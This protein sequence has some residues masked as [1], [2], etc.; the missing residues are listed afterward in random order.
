MYHDIVT[1]FLSGQCVNALNTMRR[2][3]GRDSE[4]GKE[5]RGK[6]QVLI[7][8][9]KKRGGK[10]RKEMEGGRKGETSYSISGIVVSRDLCLKFIKFSALRMAFCHGLIMVDHSFIHSSTTEVVGM[11]CSENLET[12]RGEFHSIDTTRLNFC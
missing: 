7:P 4:G 11:V 8:R 6:K 3:T 2:Y 12:I 10:K 9:F 5:G 1:F